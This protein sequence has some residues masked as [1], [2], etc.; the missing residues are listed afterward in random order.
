MLLSAGA[1][2]ATA[3]D[4]TCGS[5]KPN[6]PVA[7][8]TSSELSSKSAQLFHK[9]LAR[10]SAASSVGKRS[11]MTP[12]LNAARTRMKRALSAVGLVIV[13]GP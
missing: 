5:E 10:S 8:S 6:P 12:L 2:K 9:A 3:A 7:R 13:L 1:L 11:V 4:R